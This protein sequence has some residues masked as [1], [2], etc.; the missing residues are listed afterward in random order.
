MVSRCALV[1]LLGL[2]LLLGCRKQ[3][4]LAKPAGSRASPPPSVLATVASHLGGPVPAASVQPPRP[5]AP[6]PQVLDA[7]GQKSARTY[8]L[9]LG[10][11]RKATVAKDFE[12]AELRFSR[13]L[14]TLPKDPRALA[15]RGYARLLAGKLVE[16]RTDLSEAERSAPNTTLRLQILHN[17]AQLERKLG[18]EGAAVA[19][20]EQRAKLKAARR[21]S[22]GVDCSSDVTESDL[23]LKVVTSFQ[24][25]LKSVL[26]AHAEA[27]NSE[28]NEVKLYDFGDDEYAARVES[29]AKQQPFP[30]GALVLSTSG[31]GS[32]KNHGVIAQ[33]GKFYVYPNLSSGSLALCG[34]EGVADVTIE[35]GGARPWRIQRS[36][37]LLVRSYE[38]L[39]NCGDD[40]EARWQGSCWWSSSSMDVTYLEAGTFRGMR[41]ISA[42][43]QPSSEGTGAEPE[44]LLE[45]EWQADRVAVDACGQHRDVPYAGE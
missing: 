28:P 39:E 3:A 21:L 29:L 41:K 35:G 11:G 13:C 23:E 6:A 42:A 27:D 36:Y 4:P 8:A 10:L 25:V 1:P 44:H 37:R 31:P 17:L 26:A 24:E 2:F 34:P 7:A 9:E 5:A 38:C 19:H 20:E 16:A 12:Q 33:S 43:A 18:N 40:A 15:E 14:E 45:L 30:D 32:N 22:S